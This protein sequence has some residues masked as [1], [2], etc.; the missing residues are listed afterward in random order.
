MATDI[1][2]KF[3]GGNI[4]I[5]GESTVEGFVEQLEAHTFQEGFSNPY[6]GT[7][8]GQVAS[9]T[10]ASDVMVTTAPSQHSNLLKRSMFENNV[11]A[12]IT[13]SFL[14]QVGAKSELYEERVFTNAY[15]TSY[16]M[17]KQNESVGHEAWSLNCT[18]VLSSYKVQNPETHALED[19]S[20]ATLNLAASTS[21]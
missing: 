12:K 1:M 18:E 10:N 2:I 7:G 15:I 5:K 3:E 14:K 9:R 19:A 17:S 4:P 21:A 13:I 6:S 16:S 8:K 11:F 20:T